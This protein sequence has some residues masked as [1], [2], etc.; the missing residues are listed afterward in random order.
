MDGF[1]FQPESAPDK[2]VFIG[3]VELAAKRAAIGAAIEK[4]LGNRQSQGRPKVSANAETYPKGNTIDLAAKRAG[5]ASA[6]TFEAVEKGG[7]GKNRKET[8]PF[9]KGSRT[10]ARRKRRRRRANSTGEA[11]EKRLWRI[12]HKLS[13]V[14]RVQW[15]RSPLKPAYQNMSPSKLCSSSSMRR[16][17][18][19]RFSRAA[20][21]LGFNCGRCGAAGSY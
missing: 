4:E 5:F 11:I 12:H 14:L 8:L 17:W 19:M 1:G 2:V 6:E 10:S 13:L 21:R 7:R 20:W 18:R 16:I 9:S 3:V 15:I